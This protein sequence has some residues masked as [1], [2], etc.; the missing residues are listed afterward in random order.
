[1]SLWSVHHCRRRVSQR[2]CHQ[3]V[4]LYRLLRDPKN[5]FSREFTIPPLS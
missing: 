4:R 5:K 2:L 1:M 3:R